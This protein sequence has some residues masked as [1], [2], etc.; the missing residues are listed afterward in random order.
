MRLTRCMRRSGYTGVYSSGDATSRLKIRHV[1]IWG[2]VAPP[3][4]ATRHMR[5]HEPIHHTCCVRQIAS[6]NWALRLNR[7]ISWL[8][9][10]S[11]NTMIWSN[12]N[13]DAITHTYVLFG[14]E[15]TP[16]HHSCGTYSQLTERD[17]PA[18]SMIALSQQLVLL[19]KD[20]RSHSCH[21]GKKQLHMQ[22]LSVGEK[23]GS[24]NWCP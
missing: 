19:P 24:W 13:N 10:T 20:L 16:G 18:A 6:C 14:R 17:P 22:H 2:D 4:L 9:S 23:H 11:Q 8:S 1:G 3:S 7:H 21:S 12:C 5:L 15:N